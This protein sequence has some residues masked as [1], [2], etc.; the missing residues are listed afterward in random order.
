[1]ERIVHMQK[2]LSFL[3]SN[4]RRIVN[5]VFL[6]LGD[7]PASECCADVSE[8]KIQTPGNHPKEYSRDCCV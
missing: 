6:L 3:I 4:L 2:G 7:S 5:I 8:H 1:M